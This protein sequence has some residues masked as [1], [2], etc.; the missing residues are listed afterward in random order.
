MDIAIVFVRKN[1]NSINHS[2]CKEHGECQG[3]DR[4]LQKVVIENARGVLTI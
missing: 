4:D 1:N 3:V 2:I